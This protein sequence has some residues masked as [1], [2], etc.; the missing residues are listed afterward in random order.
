M[1]A[2]IALRIAAV[3]ALKGRTLVGN[4]VL[5]SQIGALDVD[6]N[7]SIR[8]DQQ[9][10]FISVF[11]EAGKVEG[12][13][14]LGLRALH[15]SGLTE[16]MIETGIATSMTVIDEITGASEVIPGLPATDT[17]FE[18]Y[19]DVVG[20]QIV[21]ALT[22]PDNEWAEIW[23]G[24]SSGIVKIERRRTA[25]AASGT[26]IA[27]HQIVVTLD[28]LADPIAGEAL[29]PSSIW[30]KFF[31]KLDELA[32]DDPAAAIQATEL[33]ALI[34]GTAF[35]WQAD[36]RRQGMTRDEMDAMLLV[37]PA[38]V[39]GDIDIVEINPAPAQQVP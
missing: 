21:N 29:A 8:T 22:N 12:P 20:R 2:R 13:D 19:L 17:A 9:K 28:L 38:G 4:N 37:P 32:V 34:S 11:V 5:D 35:S 30:A 31:E 23:R 16:F 26:R 36:Q 27:A 18:F 10:P 15:R 24:L 39:E 25:D 1:L 3:E 6:A 33:R 7:N 14:Q